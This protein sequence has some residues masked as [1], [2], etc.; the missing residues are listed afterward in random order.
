MSN[1]KVLFCTAAGSSYGIGHLKRC[2]AIIDASHGLFDSYIS[3]NK[4]NRDAVLRAQ[5]T[6]GEYA[7]LQ[8]MED[9][10]DISLIVSDMRET[11]TREMKK[12]GKRAPIISFDDPGAGKDY[13]I[14]S[15]FALSDE[16]K[17]EGNFNGPS[18][19]VINSA[20]K[21]KVPLSLSEKEGILVS[22]GG[23]DPHNLTGFTVA[24]LN[25]LGIRPTIVLGPLY[26]HPTDE[27]LGDIYMHPP[28]FYDLLNRTRVLIT[29]FGITMYEAFYLKTPVV[30]IN[31]SAYHNRLANK[32][33]A[34]NLGYLNAVDRDEIRAGFLRVLK[35]DLVLKR[36]VM[37]NAPLIDAKGAN[38]I[39][40]IM[41][42][43][44]G[45]LR[46]DCFFRH[47]RYSV[48]KRSSEYTLLRCKRCKDIFLHE[49]KDLPSIYDDD[50][51]LTEY[52]RQYG[53]TYIEDRE[54]I[55]QNGIRRIRFIE[56][57]HK[58]KGYLLDVGCALG[59][60]VE[61]AQERG[62]KAK[63]IE[64][65]SYASEWGK[66]NLSVDIING[67][68]L[69]VELSPDSFDALTFYY[70]AEHLKNVEELFKKASLLLKKR[71]V[72]VFALP[73][74]WGIS[75][76]I[77][78]TGFINEHPP[79]HYFDTSPRN[80]KNILK[81]YGF[82]K[83]RIHIT[84]IHPE[85]FFQRIGIK[86]EV[87]WLFKTYTFFAKIFYLGDTFEYYGIKA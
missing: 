42:H 28:D 46:K 10:R 86:H 72:V 50:Y 9:I 82:K 43:T 75:Y 30:L 58:E 21:K 62:W 55:C 52:K 5:K 8:N 12:W 14:I 56:R 60:F 24:I 74:R 26:S 63:G 83:K 61:I 2:L 36:S 39:V 23:T 7:F 44:I 80:L 85:R 38:R 65:S 11:K 69:E 41:K 4:G 27:L 53:R 22:F 20:I 77:N 37:E 34:I 35:D 54:R 15:I 64:V 70:V 78:R 81:K 3:I 45:G 59:F 48:V 67:S 73:N 66:R 19:I 51:F 79:D 25:S 6:F 76:R 87:V 13:S 16:Q 18:F 71:G 31:H 1:P 49:I 47:K 29:S 84:G 57:L 32:T 68:F 33:H 17:I 40:S